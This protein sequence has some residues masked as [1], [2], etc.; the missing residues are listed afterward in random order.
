MT[1]VHLPAVCEDVALG[2]PEVYEKAKP[3][4]GPLTREICDDYN[5]G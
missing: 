3:Y 5:M 4:L 1:V 2:Y